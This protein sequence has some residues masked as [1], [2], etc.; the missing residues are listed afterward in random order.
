MHGNYKNFK[1]YKQVSA[2]FKKNIEANGLI[3]YPLE[4]QVSKVDP[5]MLLEDQLN[6]EKARFYN[7]RFLVWSLRI[8]TG[9]SIATLT[10]EFV[11]PQTGT[12]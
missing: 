2:Q 3:G 4:L 1:V 8:K 7:N 10:V 9:G 5:T 6:D 11:F 12:V